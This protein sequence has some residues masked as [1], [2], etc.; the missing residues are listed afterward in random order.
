MKVTIKDIENEKVEFEKG[1]F[2]IIANGL[3]EFKKKYR[4]ICA[5]IPD[6]KKTKINNDDLRGSFDDTYSLSSPQAKNEKN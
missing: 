3:I 1:I 2:Y 4:Q 5:G 6:F